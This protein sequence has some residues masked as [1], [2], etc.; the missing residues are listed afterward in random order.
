MAVLVAIALAAGAAGAR[1]LA[2]S[3]GA[4]TLAIALW[5]TSSRVAVLAATVAPG[6]VL[7]IR[8]LSRGR[9]RALRVAAV[10][11][12]AVVLL[13]LAAIALP[14][15][16]SQKSSVL[17]ADVRLGLIQTGARMIA[18]H[19][20]LA[21]A[22]RVLPASRS[23]ARGLIKAFPVVATGENAHNNFVRSA[24]RSGS[25]ADCC[26]RGSSARRWSRSRAAGRRRAR[27][28]DPRPLILP[29]V[30]AFAH[31]VGGHPRSSRKPLRVLDAAGVTAGA[32]IVAELTGQTWT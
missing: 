4:V 12:A 11:A 32:A 8:E 16:G 28:R 26:S 19:R 13:L 21:S 31:R 29:A 14:Q 1:R 3:A 24:P 9:T 25:R 18:S 22:R 20:S 17:A 27:S 5:L 10:A 2:W 7:M 23:S 6:A 15:R 30:G